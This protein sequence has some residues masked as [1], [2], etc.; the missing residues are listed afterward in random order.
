MN[1]ELRR[2]LILALAIPPALGHLYH[3]ILAINV[4]SGRG[5]AERTMDWLR[6]SLFLLLL[7]TS[8]VLL[9]MHIRDPWWSWR[10]P[11]GG[12]AIFCVIS[13]MLI[14]PISSWRILSRPRP[15]GIEGFSRITELAGADEIHTLIGTGRRA[16]LLRLPRNQAFQLQRCEW[17]ISVPDLPPAL[18]GLRISQITDLHFAPCFERAYF[19]RVIEAAR[20]WETDVIVL[21]GD[22]VD[23]D[24]AI[25]WIGPVLGRLEGRIGKFAILGNHDTAHDPEAILESLERAGYETLEGRWTTIDVN[26]T[27]LAIGGTSAPWGPLFDPNAI[28]EAEFRLLLSHC[29]DLFYKAKGWGIDLMLSGH[30]HGGQ[31]RVPLLGP[32]FM[33]SRYSRRFDRGFFREGSTLMYVSEGVAGK[34]PVRYGCPPEITQFVLRAAKSNVPHNQRR[35]ASSLHESTSA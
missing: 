7:V 29:P 18:E 31:I 28:P 3:F 12:Y 35:G 2:L 34:H 6:D 16:S 9:T 32:I 20:D 24:D 11:M 30:N 27:R 13:G 5:F 26:G 1:L 10:W 14:W 17:V 15:A 4:A 22:V 8:A 25:S 23:H 19:E 21:T 33:P